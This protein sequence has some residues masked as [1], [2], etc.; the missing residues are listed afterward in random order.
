MLPIPK[1]EHKFSEFYILGQE[2]KAASYPRELKVGE[3]GRV[4]VGIANHEYETVSYRMEVR[5]YGVMNN[6]VETIVLE[7]SEKWEEIV[8]FTPHKAGAN[9]KVEFLLFREGQTEVYHTLRLW[10]DVTQ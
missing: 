6:E 2:G 9:Q 8:S 5:I 1:A 3:E 7:H 4:I 10:L